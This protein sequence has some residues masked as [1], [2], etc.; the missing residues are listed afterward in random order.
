[1]AV[2]K[3]H[4]A[5]QTVNLLRQVHGGSSEWQDIAASL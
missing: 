5:E 2:G 1:M 4:T 3:K